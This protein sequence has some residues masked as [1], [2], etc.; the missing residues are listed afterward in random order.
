M[1]NRQKGKIM[2][3]SVTEIKVELEQSRGEELQTLL[4]LYSEDA[5]KGV[6]ALVKRYYKKEEDRKKEI[7]RLEAM[8]CFERKYGDRLYFGLRAPASFS[9]LSSWNLCHHDSG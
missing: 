9:A 7:A 2:G 3:K 1:D 6:Q 8:R 5:R 4:A